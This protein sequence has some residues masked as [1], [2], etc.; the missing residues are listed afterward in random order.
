MDLKQLREVAVEQD[1]L[2]REAALA[3]PGKLVS[4]SDFAVHVTPMEMLALLDHLENQSKRREKMLNVGARAMRVADEFREELAMKRR[5]N[6]QLR[7]LIKE[8]IP[9]IGREANVPDLLEKAEKVVNP[10]HR[11]C[12]TCNGE[13]WIQTTQTVPECCGCSTT[14]ECG[15]EGCNGPEPAQ[16]PLQEACPHCGEGAEL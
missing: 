11:L 1:R 8:L 4:S 10:L 14:G 3:S 6:A 7:A 13:G 12:A 2:Y 15:G 16:A 5:A 9:F